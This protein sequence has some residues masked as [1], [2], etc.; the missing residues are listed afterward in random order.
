MAIWQDST[1]NLYDDMG[2]SALSLP[3]WPKNL[4]LLTASQAQAAQ[5][6]VP[7]QEQTV[8]ILTKAV[9]STLDKGA[10]TWNYDNIVSAA[11]YV[12]STNA[13]YAADAEVLIG[14]RD[15]VWAWAIPQF[16]TVVAGTTPQ[17]FLASIPQ[18]PLQPVITNTT[19]VS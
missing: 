11:S 7:T 12:S 1:G 19:A 17:S 14:W 3:T 4:T 9:S 16:A 15:A 10:Q 8:S 18:Q 13:Q 5:N 6:P 2:G